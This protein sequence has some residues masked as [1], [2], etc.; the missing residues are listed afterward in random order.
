MPEVGYDTVDVAFITTR[1]VEYDAMSSFTMASA[2]A[3]KGGKVTV[4]AFAYD[5]PPVDGVEI[6]LLGGKNSHSLA[7][8]VRALLETFKLARELSSYDVL[9]MVNP[10]LG[11]MPACHLARR[12]N[13]SLRIL[14]T[15]HGL[16]PPEFLSDFKDRM[17]TRLRQPAYIISM[18]RSDR[19]QVFSHFMKQALAGRGVDPV[20]VT[21]MPFGVDLARMSSGN[22]N[23]IREKYGI[24][25]RFLVLYVGRLVNFKHVDEL[26]EAIARLPEN[27]FFMVVGSGPERSRLE[28]QAKRLGV[29]ERVKF[30][31]RVSDEELPDYYAACDVWATASRHEG[32]CV[33]IVEAMAAGKPVVVPDLA[34]MPETAGDGGLTYNKGDIEDLASRL[35]RLSKDEGAYRDLSKKATARASGFGMQKVL[36][37]YMK[38]IADIP[39]IH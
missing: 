13:P 34:A 6:H 35:E 15:F 20:K 29:E 38:E 4:Y 19:T 37:T 12:Y 8:N 25:E 2:A 11:S 23:K 31:G 17:F 27:A 24:G 39:I 16:T 21:V 33:P 14:W 5:R 10:D 1:P 22:G 7:S 3:L 32:F 18:K 9:V 26:I 28:A 30:A 36:E